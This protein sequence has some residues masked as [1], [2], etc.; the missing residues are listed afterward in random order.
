MENYCVDFECYGGTIDGGF[1]QYSKVLEINAYRLDDDTDLKEAALL[2]PLACAIQG[3]NKLHIDFGDNAII[4]GIGTMGLLLMQLLKNRGVSHITMVDINQD[5][6][7]LAKQLGADSA[8][9]NDKDLE[10]NLNKTSEKGFDIL[11][12]ATGIKEV[13]QQIFDYYTINSRILLYG[14]CKPEDEI[15]IKPYELYRND[16][17]IFGAFAFSKDKLLSAIRLLENNK[18]DLKSL[19]TDVISLDEFQKGMKSIEEGKTV[20]TVFDCQL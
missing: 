12:D 1:A 13:C 8:F 19:V 20:K 9:L 15:K 17:S 11:I 2:E 6:F 14:V 16:L 4:F 10:N 3:I 18:I 7:E 5:K